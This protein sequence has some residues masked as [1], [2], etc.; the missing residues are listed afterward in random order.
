MI[1]RFVR[2]A[3][4]LF[5]SAPILKWVDAAAVC[6]WFR[7]VIPAARFCCQI[8]LLFKLIAIALYY[9]KRLVILC[10]FGG[11][12]D[13]VCSFP[14]VREFIRRNADVQVVYV[15]R[16]SFRELIQRSN[17]AIPCVTVGMHVVLAGWAARLVGQCIALNYADEAEIMDRPPVHLV[18][19]FA[20]SLGLVSV[21][22]E[23]V[24]R[25]DPL[26]FEKIRTHYLLKGKQCFVL[27]HTGPTWKVREW[28]LESWI[29]LVSRLQE[30]PEIQVFQI[31]AHRNTTVKG[32]WCPLVPG[33]VPIECADNLPKL[34]DTIGAADLLIGIDSGPVHVATALGTNCVAL[35][36][37]TDPGLRLGPARIQVVV[38]RL[39]CSFC[40]H[41]RPRL[42]W[43]TGCPMQIA[44]MKNIIVEQVMHKV[45][46]FLPPH[47]PNYKP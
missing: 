11:I 29:T 1:G 45:G 20:R 37:P 41:R 15:T 19:E 3:H 7:G 33:A 21:S 32:A 12:G 40:H 43:Q 9:R 22:E 8:G 42:H 27:L 16:T 18:Q 36:G 2:K 34:I 44:C 13:I 23:P 25:I 28:P 24:L 4:H 47:S 46:V 30:N 38:H 17:L 5:K 6:L 39:D 31:V 35:F 10:R 26:Q 14:A